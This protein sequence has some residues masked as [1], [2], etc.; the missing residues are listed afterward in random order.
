MNHKVNIFGKVVSYSLVILE[1]SKVWLWLPFV[2]WL[3]LLENR[4][5]VANFSLH[6]STKLYILSIIIKNQLAKKGFKLSL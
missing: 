5:R 4:R 3:N 1:A 6:T 2:P